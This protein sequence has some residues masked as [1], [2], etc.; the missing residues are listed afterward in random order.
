M[1]RNQLNVLF[2]GLI[3]YF[4]LEGC[5]FNYNNQSGLSS[6][7]VRKGS[8][9][10]VKPEKLALYKKLHANPWKGVNKS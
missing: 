7:V 5:N 9:I 3:F 4:L 2:F 10:K 8:V 1:S 6:E